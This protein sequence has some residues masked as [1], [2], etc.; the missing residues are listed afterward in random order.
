MR[1]IEGGK[2][3]TI[4]HEVYRLVRDHGPSVIAY[5]VTMAADELLARGQAS[6]DILEYTREHTA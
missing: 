3:G 4:Y 1:R 5:M 2:K 6:D